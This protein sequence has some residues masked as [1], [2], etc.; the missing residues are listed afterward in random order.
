MMIAARNSFLM[1]GGASTP[2]ARDY[3][4]DGLVAMFDTI[5]NVAFGVSDHSDRRVV[6]LVGG[7]PLWTYNLAEG[8]VF[9]ANYITSQTASPFASN[10]FTVDRDPFSYIEV[11]FTPNTFSNGA[12][13]FCLSKGYSYG[14]KH[15]MIEYKNAPGGAVLQPYRYAPNKEYAVF[16]QSPALGTR[17]TL[18]F[19]CSGASMT[20]AFRNG[21]ELRIQSG[22]A[23]SNNAVTGS[24]VWGGQGVNVRTTP[25][26]LM[27]SARLYSRT[28]TAAEVAANYAI[29]AARFGL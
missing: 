20:A 18:C 23:S 29:D 2:T 3:V 24:G 26:W 1:G 13:I 28:L 17:Y 14:I 4:Q 25:G 21:V 10:S 7:D 12:F 8:T 6:N 19:A 11:V 22:Y 9:G 15:T 5:E 27:H 16:D